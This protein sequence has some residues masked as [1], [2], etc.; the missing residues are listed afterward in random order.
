[1]VITTGQSK[2]ELE[3]ATPPPYTTLQIGLMRP[4][5]QL[6]A[7][8][9]ARVL[10]MVEQG[11]VAE[12]EALLAAGYAPTL[13]AMTSLGYREMTAYLRG[14]MTLDAAITRLQT[15]THRYVRRQ[16]TWFRKMPDVIWFDL[17]EPGNEARMLAH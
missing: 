14:E 8:I 4:R 10:A 12:T 5:D 16:M 2:T 3:G 15:E 6:Y 9:D 1:I 11:L 7:R 13:P 17:S